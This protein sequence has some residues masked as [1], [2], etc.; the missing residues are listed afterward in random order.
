VASLTAANS[1]A[2]W[3]I[4]SPDGTAA[5]YRVRLAP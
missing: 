3:P 5:F 2:Q 1:L 4:P